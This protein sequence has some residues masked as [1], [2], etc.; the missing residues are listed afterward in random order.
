VQLSHVVVR[1]DLTRDQLTEY[2]R[3][4]LE[5]TISADNLAQARQIVENA[6]GGEGG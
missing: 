4:Q 1:E 5:G 6:R 2:A 3:S